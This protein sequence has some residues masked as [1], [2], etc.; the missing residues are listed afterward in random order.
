MAKAEALQHKK[1]VHAGHRASGTRIQGQITTALGAT[2]PNV[3]RLSMLKLTLE[4]KQKTLKE[5]DDEI[6]ALVPGEELDAEI[7]QADECQENIFEVLVLI[8]RTLTPITTPEAPI[9]TV[10]ELFSV[11]PRAHFCSTQK[12]TTIWRDFW[13]QMKQWSDVY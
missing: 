3:E 13:G 11:C 9:T 4:A 7:Q 2:P 12:S 1:R 6:V 8:N 10:P 5:L